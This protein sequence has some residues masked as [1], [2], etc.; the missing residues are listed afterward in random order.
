MA[1]KMFNIFYANINKIFPKCFSVIIFH[2]KHRQKKILDPSLLQAIIVNNSPC[3]WE[4]S[5]NKAIKPRI[6]LFIHE[7][8][9]V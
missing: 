3:S 6:I 1:L 4:F 5:Q 9:V 8:S 2:S 7:L